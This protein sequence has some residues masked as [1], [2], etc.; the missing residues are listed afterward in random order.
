MRQTYLVLLHYKRKM[1]ILWYIFFFKNCKA[2]EW[3]NILGNRL[4]FTFEGF[5]DV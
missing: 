4:P 5:Q 2:H 1:I 3:K